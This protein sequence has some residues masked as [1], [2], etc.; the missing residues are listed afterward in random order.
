MAQP[1]VGVRVQANAVGLAWVADEL[2]AGVHRARVAVEEIGRGNAS[3]EVVARG[4]GEL[5]RLGAVLALLEYRGLAV[6][7]QEMERNVRALVADARAVAE[8]DRRGACEVLMTALLRAGDYLEFIGAGNPD[9]P[10]VLLPLVNDLRACRGAPGVG[11]DALLAPTLPVPAREPTSASPQHER[12]TLHAARR[13]LQREL[14]RWIRGSDDGPRDTRRILAAIER[15]PIPPRLR[16]IA[17]VAGGLVSAAE[18]GSVEPREVQRL[19]ARL[20]QHLRQAMD[21]VDVEAVASAGTALLGTLLAQASRVR[22]ASAGRIAEVQAWFELG[23]LRPGER[24][25]DTARDAIDGPGLGTLRALQTVLVEEI[26]DIES[27]IEAWPVREGAKA[28][29]AFADIPESL[30]RLAHSLRL[31]NLDGVGID[32]LEQAQQLAALERMGLSP[33]PGDLLLVAEVLLDARR[34]L[35]TAARR[36]LREA[37]LECERRRVASDELRLSALEHAAL[38]AATL[39]ELAVNLA[40]VK[41]LF[42]EPVDA[43]ALRVARLGAEV[44]Q[45]VG[46]LR[47]LGLDPVAS[48]L[49]RWGAVCATVLGR[50]RGTTPVVVLDATAEVLAQIEFHLEAVIGR[51]PSAPAALARAQGRIAA[52]ERAVTK[53]DPIETPPAPAPA[54]VASAE[55]EHDQEV[56]TTFVEEGRAVCGGLADLVA[57][58]TVVAPEAA[59]LVSLRRALHTLAGSGRIAGAHALAELAGAVER[60]LD[61]VIDHAAR[62]SRAFA[63][64]LRQVAEVLPP[65]LED[66]ARGRPGSLDVSVLLRRAAQLGDGA[67]DGPLDAETDPPPA[68]GL[69][70]GAVASAVVEAPASPEP[71]AVRPSSVA[72][73]PATEASPRANLLAEAIRLHARALGEALDA[74]GEG[75]AIDGVLGHV[76]ALQA[77]A[78]AAG[79]TEVAELCTAVAAAAGVGARRG[80]HLPWARLRA[81]IDAAESLLARSGAADVP[82]TEGEAGAEPTV[83]VEELQEVFADDSARVLDA[84]ERALAEWR[85]DP[86]ARGPVQEL[87]RELHTL[88]GSAHTVGVAAVGDLGHSLESVLTLVAS[89]RIRAT[90]AL[91]DA[92]ERCL[93]RMAEMTDLARAG[94]PVPAAREVVARLDALV[95]AALWTP[96]GGP[97]RAQART[98]PP[99]E[100]RT[101]VGGAHDTVT[102]RDTERPDRGPGSGHL[103]DQ[104]GR[105]ARSLS[106]AQMRLLRALERVDSAVQ[107][108][109]EVGTTALAEA[110]HELVAQSHEQALLQLA[111]LRA[112]LVPFAA[113]VPR[114]QRLAR[115]TFEAVGKR[116]DLHVEGASTEVDRGVSERV[117]VALEHLLRNAI[118][119]GIEL[120]ARR[121]E[122]GKQAV[123]RVEVR[124]RR[125]G[126]ELEVRLR[127][128][129][130]G[131]DRDAIRAVAVE[132]GLLAATDQVDEAAVDR[133]IFSPGL[134]TSARVT[135]ISGRGVG[136]DTVA[137]EVAQLG[138]TI[139][140]ES[141]PG[142]GTAFT[143][144]VPHGPGLDACLLLEVGGATVGL[145]L[146]QVDSVRL[147]PT[148][149]LTRMLADAS[150]EVRHDERAYPLRNLGELLELDEGVLPDP[151][152]TSPVVL[153]SAGEQRIALV[154][155]ALVGQGA[156]AR[157]APPGEALP[158]WAAGSSRAGDAEDV[159]V[160]DLAR[161]LQPPSVARESVGARAWRAVPAPPEPKILVV[162]DSVTVRKMTRR[163]LVRHGFDVSTAKDGV[164]ALAMIRHQ[165]PDAVVLDIE[166]PR[167]DGF[168][169]TRVLRADDAFGDLPIVMITSRVGEKHAHRARDLGVNRYLGKP[170][171]DGDL[172]EAIRAV[173]AKSA[174]A[175]A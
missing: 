48:L 159:P 128:D 104:L 175:T 63:D 166:M 22:D 7:F 58:A 11:E 123:G 81:L 40:R 102:G 130:A 89:G 167:M 144:S 161:L 9:A 55:T 139:G 12:E 171:Q 168:E 84:A 50:P 121:A 67:A 37:E 165:R 15:A 136:L 146:L 51:Q 107:A 173:L 38:T 66:F 20:E 75:T 116:G 133:L 147:I 65:M 95:F 125:A 145:P 96:P 156:A 25:Y 33:M 64:L 127:D 151:Q 54:A 42:D 36:G 122:L 137:A 91:L 153:A 49:E 59:A 73:A 92:V 16:M 169:L 30:G 4:A 31:L 46:A 138:G 26:A 149:D 85:A 29:G 74:R 28:L 103:L 52:L 3:E 119:H 56:R 10:T 140:V 83:G 105:A 135:R 43:P 158:P 87:Q 24:R 132:R 131:L 163:L 71:G 109:G 80:A 97:V 174:A 19:L 34:V 21:G 69:A 78:R 110:R 113:F 115:R 45:G 41:R 8:D 72:S 27:R 106:G 14:A 39:G 32:V 86:D 134:S 99:V 111:L 88:K 155:Q 77:C 93:D 129:G 57:S 23:G 90:P 114:L 157:P 1:A 143:I 170:Y 76:W 148:A 172:L 108:S 118:D 35:D 141:A 68:P 160:V 142:R 164:E 162:D 154:A 100:E 62:P 5:H 70:P 18:V 13:Y 124:V 101:H 6:L 126:R 79:H 120:P 44:A 2:A 82:G 17:W 94:Q 98:V 61:V 47:V 112:R 117:A 152:S 53:L 150:A 60:V